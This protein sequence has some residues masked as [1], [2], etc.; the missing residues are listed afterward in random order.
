MR[1]MDDAKEI[2][3]NGKFFRVGVVSRRIWKELQIK[4]AGILRAF[5]GFMEFISKSKEEVEGADS[6]EIGKRITQNMSSEELLKADLAL[7]DVHR[8]MVKFG[9]R[10]HRGLLDKEGREI[11]FEKDE[12]GHVKDELIDLYDLN[13]FFTRLAT[14]VQAFNNLTEDAKKN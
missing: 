13:G 10:G 11:V 4:S 7:Y 8:E 3:I 14:E 6:G 2:E 1:F 12:L 5:P 9:V